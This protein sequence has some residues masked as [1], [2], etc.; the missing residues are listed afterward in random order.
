M[1]AG[2]T[3]T[4][5]ELLVATEPVKLASPPAVQAV[6]LVLDQVNVELPL[7]R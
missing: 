5:V 4:P 3:V 2:L 6:A 1:V 7:G